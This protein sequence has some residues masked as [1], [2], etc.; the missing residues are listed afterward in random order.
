V[1]YTIAALLAAAVAVTLDLLV[2]RTNLLLTKGFWVADA[3]VVFFQ[4][5]VN[6]LLTG[7]RIVQYD[8]ARIIGWRIAYAPAEDLVFGFALVTAT[9]CLWEALTQPRPGRAPRGD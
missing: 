8:P 9:M 1:S 5:I 7:L 2:L 4:L 6:G 3:I